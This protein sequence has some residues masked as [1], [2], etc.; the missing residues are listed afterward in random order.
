MRYVT[1]SLM[2][3]TN[4]WGWFC[5]RPSAGSTANRNRPILYITSLSRRIP[6]EDD[7]TPCLQRWAA[8]PQAVCQGRQA[9]GPGARRPIIFLSA[10]MTPLEHVEP[11]VNF[12]GT[13][14]THL[15]RGV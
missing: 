5:A 14:R 12:Q 1:P 10:P 13:C 6:Q 3:K 8:S 7:T 4:G 15:R 2:P 9:V 11:Y